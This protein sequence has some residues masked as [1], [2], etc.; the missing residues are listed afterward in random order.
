MVTSVSLAT[1]TFSAIS[2]DVAFVSSSEMMSASSPRM[3]PSALA[4]RASRSSSSSFSLI[5][6]EFCASTSSARCSSRSSRSLETT[7]PSSWS[8][9]PFS[10]T[11]KLMRL[12]CAWISGM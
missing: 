2:C 5:V 12:V 10:V 3:S 11:E 1:M 9:S 7:T 4:S 8:S 6:Y